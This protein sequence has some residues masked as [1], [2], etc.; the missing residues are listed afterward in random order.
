MTNRSPIGVFFL[1]LF[2]GGIYGYFW[3]YW[4]KQE[5]IALGADIPTMWL[6]LIPL[7]SIY[8]HWKW[9]EGTE[10]ATAGRLSGA[11]SFLLTW[12]LGGIGYAII[13]SKFN[14]GTPAI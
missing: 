1:T 14:E 10:K 5:M 7:V 11:S 8:W 12:L 13:Q 2:T 4:T 6:I 3:L 9:S